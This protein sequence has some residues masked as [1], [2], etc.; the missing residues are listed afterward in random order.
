M[1]PAVLYLI[2]AILVASCVMGPAPIVIYEDKRDS[3]RLKF[4]QKAG[5][6]HSHPHSLTSDQMAA[7]LRGVRVMSRD[8]IVGLGLLDREGGPPFSGPEIALLAP[9]LSEGLRKASPTDVVT[10][11]LT[12]GDPRLGTLITSGGIFVRNAHLYMILANF[13][14]PP[15]SGPFE[16]MAYE[17]DNRD[18]PLSPIARY[19]FTMGF[20]PPQVRIPNAKA[21]EQDGYGGYLDESK[22]LV[23]DLPRLMTETQTPA[24]KATSPSQKPGP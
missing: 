10:F 15:S 18:E 14:T 12:T 2:V 21:K 22:L 9:Y 23:L 6:G 19:A 24:T 7:V 16:G 1:T 20:S 5:S 11:Y 13:R 17:L 8:T 4:D 3:I